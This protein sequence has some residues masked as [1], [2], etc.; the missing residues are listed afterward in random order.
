M[1]RLSPLA[2][3]KRY[4]KREHP[5]CF[6]AF[7]A[8]S[9]IT[10]RSNR[11][12]DLDLVVI[13]GRVEEPFQLNTFRYGWLIEAFVMTPST[14]RD[15]FEEARKRAIPTLI[16]MCAEGQIV[17]GGDGAHQVQREAARWLE[18]GPAEWS[19]VELDRARYE[20]TECLI[21]LETPNIPEEEW[22]LV[23]QLNELVT[24]FI[25]RTRRAWGGIG[26]WRYR[27]LVA[28]APG[29]ADEWTGLLRQYYTHHHKQPMIAFVDRLLAPYGGRLQT[30]VMG[31]GKVKDHH[32][33]QG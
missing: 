19:F 10:D 33:N 13:D 12:S 1:G 22:Y 20:L 31:L 18:E 7:V 9:A 27:S 29:L 16:R 17:H 2:A 3:A 24:T 32:E 14:Y 28:A 5:D 6:A 8:G 15:F 4:V 21:D 11:S 23:H 25:L 30:G 26:K